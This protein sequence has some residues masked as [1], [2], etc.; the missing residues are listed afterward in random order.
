MNVHC[1]SFCY[2]FSNKKQPP[3]LKGNSSQGRKQ[4]NINS[5]KTGRQLL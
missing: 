5:Q 3:V 4:Q 1:S 2:I